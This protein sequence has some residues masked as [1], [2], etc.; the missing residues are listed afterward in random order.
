MVS[1]TDI[2]PPKPLRPRALHNVWALRTQPSGAPWPCAPQ[3]RPDADATWGAGQTEHVV[4]PAA[5]E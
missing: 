5:G 2:D 3:A 4:A 1:A